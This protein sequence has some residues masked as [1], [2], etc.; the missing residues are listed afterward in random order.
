MVSGTRS[1]LI[2]CMR[3]LSRFNFLLSFLLQSVIEARAHYN[4][5][6]QCARRSGD[7]AKWQEDCQAVKSRAL[8]A[9]ADV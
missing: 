1:C 8:Q 6:E 4:A 2:L 5:L 3:F 9:G 7:P